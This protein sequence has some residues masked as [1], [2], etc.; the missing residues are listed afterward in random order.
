MNNF[1]KCKYCNKMTSRYGITQCMNCYQKRENIPRLRKLKRVW[2]YYCSDCHKKTTFYATR[3]RE[4]YVIFQKKHPEAN[5]F[6][7]KHHSKESIEKAV[8]SRKK[9][10]SEY[11]KRLRENNPVHD[12]QVRLKILKTAFQKG[13]KTWNKGKGEYLPQEIRKRVIQS[14]RRQKKPP[15]Y[16][17]SLLY[18]FLS[19]RSFVYTGDGTIVKINGKYPDFLRFADN[20]II[21]VYGEYWHRRKNIAWHQTVKGCKKFYSRQG[22]SAC[23]VWEKDIKSGKAFQKIER[24][25]N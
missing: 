16:I 6:F 5:P 22:Y 18:V 13:H 20:K 19:K 10:M 4:C 17:E 3:C 25:L 9:Y 21:E 1:P 23:I 14:L 12:P 24:W 11:S 8:N 2:R 7:G 15:N